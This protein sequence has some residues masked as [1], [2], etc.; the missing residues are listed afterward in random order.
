MMVE[1][2]F[3]VHSSLRSLRK[4]F[5]RQLITL[6]NLTKTRH[7]LLMLGKV[8]VTFTRFQTGYFQGKYGNLDSRVIS[9]GPCQTP[10]LGFCVQR[11]L[12]IT[13][14]K[15]EKYWALHPYGI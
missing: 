8:G 4:T 6:L 12:Q 11:Y 10:T 7:W 3:I 1:E 13:T 5:Q 2:R 14:F 9:Y 15:A